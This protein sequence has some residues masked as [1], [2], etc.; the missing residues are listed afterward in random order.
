MDIIEGDEKASFADGGPQGVEE[1]LDKSQSG[2]FIVLRGGRVLVFPARRGPVA[3]NRNG[4][5]R[6]LTEH[7]APYPKVVPEDPFMETG[8]GDGDPG[9]SGKTAEFLQKAAF[10]YTRRPGE[11]KPPRG[12]SPDRINEGNK[13]GK[14]LGPADKTSGID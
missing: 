8:P 4:G 11:K 6:K 1:L 14:L 7:P 2:P 9:R 12:P 13:T 3:E 5:R 10:S